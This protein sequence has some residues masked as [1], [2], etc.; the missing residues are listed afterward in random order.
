MIIE[1]YLQ[2]ENDIADRLTAELPFANIYRQAAED[3]TTTRTISTP[4]VWI[5]YA[6]F[7]PGGSSS[8]QNLQKVSQ[9]WQISAVVD[10]P[11]YI[12]V[13][14]ILFVQMVK[15]LKDYKAESWYKKAVLVGDDR[16]LNRWDLD[17]QLA[18]IPAMFEI[19][20]VI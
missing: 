8:S 14:G 7:K 12:V 1:N 10:R 19:E 5:S 3:D 11:D 6:G 16:D 17:P 18:Y 20:I 9:L 13:G 15:A 4:A 2:V